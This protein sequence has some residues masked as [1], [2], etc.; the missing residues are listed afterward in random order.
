MHDLQVGVYRIRPGSK[1]ARPLHGQLLQDLAR[2]D[3]RLLGSRWAPFE[4]GGQPAGYRPQTYSP[5]RKIGSERDEPDATAILEPLES[6]VGGGRGVLG[7]RPTIGDSHQ[8]EA[9]VRLVGLIERLWMILRH[10]RF[11]LKYRSNL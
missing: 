4:S 8:I 10:L 6:V 1:R 7:G 2:N 3:G 9:P 11:A 5:A